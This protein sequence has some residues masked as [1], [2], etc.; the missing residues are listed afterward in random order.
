VKPILV[1]NNHRF[2]WLAREE[3]EREYHECGELLAIFSA[4]SKKS[5]AGVYLKNQYTLQFASFS[6]K[7]FKR[8]QG[9]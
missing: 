2:E 9:I 7:A 5:V 8:I 6:F 3:I 1:R 4:I